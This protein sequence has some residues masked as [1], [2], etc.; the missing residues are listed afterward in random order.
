MTVASTI[1]T[2][3]KNTTCLLCDP[4]GYYFL[5]ERIDSALHCIENRYFL[6]LGADNAAFFT[7]EQAIA[8]M[9]FRNKEQL[10]IVHAED[11]R[12]Q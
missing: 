7:H 5:H 9:Q 10:R 4:T 11:L 2:L 3:L 6:S 1:L 8:I 12:P